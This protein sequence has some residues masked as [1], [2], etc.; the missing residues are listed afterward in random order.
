MRISQDN[1]ILSKGDS[2]KYFKFIALLRS[3]DKDKSR[4]SKF[5]EISSRIDICWKIASKTRFKTVF[6]V[7]L[8]A[9]ADQKL[10][11]RM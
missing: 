3:P 2:E 7:L 8:I 1:F 6:L 10:I 4:M 11:D 9:K 5:E